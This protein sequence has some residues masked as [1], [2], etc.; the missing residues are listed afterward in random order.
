M[1]GLSCSLVPGLGLRLRGGGAA[2]QNLML[3]KRTLAP[4]GHLTEGAAACSSEKSYSGRLHRGG[5]GPRVAPSAVPRGSPQRAETGQPPRHPSVPSPDTG[6]ALAAQ[7]GP[8]LEPMASRCL[9]ACIFLLPHTAATRR[10][11]VF[12]LLQRGQFLTPCWNCFFDLMFIA[13][14]IIPSSLPQRTLPLCL[15]AEVPLF[16]IL[17]TCRRQEGRNEHIPCLRLAI[18]R[19]VCKVIGLFTL[20]PHLPPCLICKRSWSPAPQ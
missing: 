17:S 15:L 1:F 10:G 4:L 14:V 11:N 12:Q 7:E 3:I 16:R 8:G 20:L 9:S 19:D 2:L 6:Q 13:C 18:L 5:R